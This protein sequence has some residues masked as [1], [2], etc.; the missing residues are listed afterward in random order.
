MPQSNKVENKLDI[1][2]SVWNKLEEGKGEMIRPK[3][4]WHK[5]ANKKT[6][7]LCDLQNEER[8]RTQENFKEKV[9]QII[10]DFYWTNR[11]SGVICGRNGIFSVERKFMV[12]LSINR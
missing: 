9:T 10:E 11:R 7:R 2:K 3:I 6:V 12:F 8:G 1:W 5:K 4:R